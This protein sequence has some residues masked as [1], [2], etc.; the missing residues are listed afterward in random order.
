VEE[1]GCVRHLQFTQPLRIVMN[2]R[3]SQGVILK[4]EER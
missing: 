2:S 4:P 3:T 1:Q